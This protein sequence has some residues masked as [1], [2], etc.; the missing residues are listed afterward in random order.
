[1]PV[2]QKKR[3][4]MKGKVPFNTSTRNQTIKSLLSVPVSVT[5]DV[6]E[7]TPTTETQ[8]EVDQSD[9]L[10]ILSE[11]QDKD[12]IKKNMSL[13]RIKFSIIVQTTLGQRDHH[14]LLSPTLI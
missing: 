12:D 6:K 11:T 13:R 8:T 14:H 4:G 1:M 9:S 7:E 3:S 2:N 5:V 10:P